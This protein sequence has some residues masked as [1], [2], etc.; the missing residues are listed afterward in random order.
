MSKE[1]NS[2]DK[3][4]PKPGP[5][6]PGLDLQMLLSNLPDAVFEL[7]PMNGSAPESQQGIQIANLS[8]VQT[9]EGAEIDAILKETLLRIEFS[10][11]V[12]SVFAKLNGGVFLLISIMVL[13]EVILVLRGI[14]VPDQRLM[15][16][17]IVASLI[18]GTVLQGGVAFIA[19]VKYLF[20]NEDKKA[21]NSKSAS[22]SNLHLARLSAI[23]NTSYMQN[24]TLH[25]IPSGVLPP[26]DNKSSVSGVYVAA[27]LIIGLI[28]GAVFWMPDSIRPLDKSATKAGDVA[29]PK[30]DKAEAATRNEGCLSP[31]V[32]VSQSVENNYPQPQTFQQRQSAPSKP[33]PPA[34]K[35]ECNST[36]GQ[37]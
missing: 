35:N 36:A 23:A 17:T 25:Q 33:T 22:S 26:H 6:V 37:K 13:V 18:G 31:Q 29:T 11:E 9:R 3:V 16:T 28:L 2:Q 27:S 21:V 20:P 30:L 32:I 34:I 1:G 10:R 4:D 19:I 24:G 8:S 7:N 5:E 12:R 14:I 15:N